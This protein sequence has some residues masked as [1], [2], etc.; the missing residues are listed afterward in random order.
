MWE[1]GYAVGEGGADGGG[2]VGFR[3][4]D[5]EEEK[6]CTVL[7]EDFGGCGGGWVVGQGC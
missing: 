1:E 2:L 5:V 7:V 6:V 3:V 4:G